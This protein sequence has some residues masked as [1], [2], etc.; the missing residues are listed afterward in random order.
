ML[1]SSSASLSRS[2][3]R[4]TTLVALITRGA[5]GF[6]GGSIVPD[7]PSSFT[8]RA[9]RHFAT[10]PATSSDVQVLSKISVTANNGSL[11]RIRHASESTKTDMVFGL[12]LP[13][14]HGKVLRSKG[15]STPALFWLSGLTCDDTNFST[16]AGAFEAAER[17]G[18]ALVIPDT[19][20][21]GEK[22]ADDGG[23]DLGQGAGFYVDA[24]Q[25]PWKD[26]FQMYSY[27]AKELPKIVQEHYNV[28]SVKS[29]AGH[30][31]GGKRSQLYSSV[32]PPGNFFDLIFLLSPSLPT[33]QRSI[34]IV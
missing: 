13:S 9:T 12:F 14:S 5:E 22:V 20:P 10:A 16:K 1:P 8:R 6:V 32:L 25:E 24:T 4:S 15:Q 30:S 21:R 23:Y 26:N 17:Q 2:L 34:I 7:R 19:S 31:M 3:L 18:I 28:G 11:L 33:F 27:V 29:I